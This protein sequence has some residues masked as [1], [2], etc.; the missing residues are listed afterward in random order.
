MHAHTQYT[1]AICTH[2]GTLQL[3]RAKEEKL[4]TQQVM[5]TVYIEICCYTHKQFNELYISSDLDNFQ[6]W[7]NTQLGDT[8]LIF[9]ITDPPT[10][11]LGKWK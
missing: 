7:K 11:F 5:H 6:T 9:R 1:A 3:G 10:L 8:N 4:R 2:T